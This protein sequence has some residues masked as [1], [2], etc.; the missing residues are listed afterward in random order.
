VFAGA[1]GTVEPGL[2]AASKRCGLRA[3]GRRLRRCLLLLP[4]F[5]AVLGLDPGTSPEVGGGR[6][7]GATS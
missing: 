7:A 2:V 1:L 4:P 3:P 6:S 5:F